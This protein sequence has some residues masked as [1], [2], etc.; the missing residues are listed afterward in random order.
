MNKQDLQD[1]R[2]ALALS[3]QLF[4]G[5][6]M[7]FRLKKVQ[8]ALRIANREYDALV[9]PVTSKFDAFVSALQQ[10][11][12]E[13]GVQLSTSSYDLI[14]VRDIDSDGPIYGGADSIVNL[15]KEKPE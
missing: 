12:I 15:T 5:E 3:C 10:V 4:Q 1:I 2:E 9:E 14:E 13:H 6:A 7:D 11:C 8:K